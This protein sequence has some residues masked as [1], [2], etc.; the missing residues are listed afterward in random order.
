MNH[1]IASKYS[2]WYN[3][4]CVQTNCRSTFASRIEV[5]PKHA[6]LQ[7]SKNFD[8]S[9]C[10]LRT[11]ITRRS[12]S[13]RLYNSSN[14]CFGCSKCSCLRRCMR[15]RI[16]VVKRYLSS[17]IGFHDFLVDTENKGV[18]Y[19]SELTFLRCSSNV[20]TTC[21]VFQKLAFICLEV[22]RARKT[23]VRFDSAWN[24]H[25]VDCCLLSG[26]YA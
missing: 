11:W 12:H 1:Q 4:A 26:S 22:L 13:S 2:P 17:A 25:I 6:F 20:V 15:A 16:V 7:V 23:L 3:L 14:R 10:F 5:F 19:H 18:V 9:V 8:L 21:L 24:T